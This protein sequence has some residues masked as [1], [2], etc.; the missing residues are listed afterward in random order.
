[1]AMIWEDKVPH[2]VSQLA[3]ANEARHVLVEHL[4]AAAVL[5]RLA[6]VAEAARAVQDSLEGLKVD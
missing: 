2:T 5:F 3:N 4:E 1:M 6:W